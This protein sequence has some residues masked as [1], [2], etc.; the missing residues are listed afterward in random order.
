MTPALFGCKSY[1]L[2]GFDRPAHLNQINPSSGISSLDSELN[3]C[4]TNPESCT[5]QFYKI[6]LPSSDDFAR[7]KF[8]EMKAK[9]IFDVKRNALPGMMFQYNCNFGVKCIKVE[10]EHLGTL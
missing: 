10:V 9:L 7:S 1:V 5:G 3:D 2:I 8:V 4:E 6:N